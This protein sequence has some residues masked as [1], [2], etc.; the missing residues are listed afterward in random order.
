MPN[1]THTAQPI[2]TTRTAAA[3][4]IITFIL[5]GEDD[6]QA[7]TEEEFRN[8]YPSG[9]DHEC[10]E[11]VWQIAV[12]KADALDNHEQAFTAWQKEASHV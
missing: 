7:M 2:E 1:M 8:A 10:E 9:P 4:K 11:F 5:N 6:A 3:E 12:S